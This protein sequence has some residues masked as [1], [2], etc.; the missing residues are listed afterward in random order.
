[1]AILWSWNKDLGTADVVD[2]HGNLILRIS[3]GED[4]LMERCASHLTSFLENLAPAGGRIPKF[5][6]GSLVVRKLNQGEVHPDIAGK[7]GRVLR[8][9]WSDTQEGYIYV[10]LWQISDNLKA[11]TIMTEPEMFLDPA[12]GTASPNRG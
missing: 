6:V 8:F 12:P 4:D 5:I 3:H 9:E 1:M 10:V 11:G 2:E 7:T